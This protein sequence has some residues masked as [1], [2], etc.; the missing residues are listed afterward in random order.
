MAITTLCLMIDPVRVL[1]LSNS[2]I[3]VWTVSDIEPLLGVVD[4]DNIPK[5][6]ER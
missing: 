4:V 1:L 6:H 2:S 3:R 5:Y